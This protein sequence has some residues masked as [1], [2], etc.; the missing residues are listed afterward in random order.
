MPK[1]EKEYGL[2]DYL[3]DRFHIFTN[4]EFDRL[5]EETPPIDISIFLRGGPND[6]YGSAEQGREPCRVSSV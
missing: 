2:C 4:G 3:H 1:Q 5:L 6:N